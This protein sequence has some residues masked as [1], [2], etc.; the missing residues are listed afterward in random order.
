MMA[1]A[2]TAGVSS[3]P[4]AYCLLLSTPAQLVDLFRELLDAVALDDLRLDKL[5]L[6]RRNHG[7]VARE[8]LRH[9]LD[10]LIAE[11][12]GLLYD[13]V[14]DRADFD[15]RE[16]LVLLVEG[17]DLHLPRLPGVAHRVQNRRPVVAP[18][19][20]ETSDIRV[21]DERVRDVRLRAH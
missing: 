6:V 4:T 5:P 2:V 15:A 9:H 19:A 21:F 11:L 12:V 18:Q 10:C 14:V 13:R 1:T 3:L 8:H 20:D 17:N 7:L 16:R